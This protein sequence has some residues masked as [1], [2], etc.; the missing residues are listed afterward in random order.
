[1]S[2]GSVTAPASDVARVGRAVAG[3]RSDRRSPGSGSHQAARAWDRPIGP[4]RE[5]SASAMPAR[6]TAS[7]MESQPVSIPTAAA[8]DAD[9]KSTRL[10][11]SHVAIS[12]AVFCLKKKNKQTALEE[13][14]KIDAT[15]P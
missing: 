11:S 14:H 12:Y 7:R 9:R 2:T 3:R 13:A 10:N 5:S 6:A 4:V 8:G 15:S 1:M